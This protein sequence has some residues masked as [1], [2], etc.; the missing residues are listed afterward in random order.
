ME[1]KEGTRIPEMTFR[2]RRNGDWNNI[3]SKDF[4]AGRRVVLFALP[5][6]FTPTCSSSHLPRYDELAPVFKKSGV[7]EVACLSVNDGFTM[8]AWG[9]TQGLENVTLLPDGNGEFS[10]G[11]GFLVDKSELG[12]GKRS[13]RYSMLVDDGV[14]EKMFIEE[15]KP[16]DPFEVSDADTMLNHLN[17]SAQ[18]PPEVTLFTKPGCEFCLKSKELLTQRGLAFETIELS[19]GISY[20]SLRNITGQS[21][22]PQIYID[23]TRIG[24]FEELK[25]HLAAL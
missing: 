13:W 22:A 25:Q 23:G 2:S 14:I 16:G 7:D 18:L 6:A 24:G 8:E 5:G 9:E 1:N 4:F 17:A 12:F 19:K 21:T 3:Q 10:A 20:K 11:L 15:E